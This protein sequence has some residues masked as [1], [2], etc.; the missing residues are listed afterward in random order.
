M[1][2]NSTIKETQSKHWVSFCFE[3]GKH[4]KVST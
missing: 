3:R 1:I 2:Q 4:V